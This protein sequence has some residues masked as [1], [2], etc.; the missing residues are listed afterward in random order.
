MVL[1]RTWFGWSFAAHV[2]PASL[3]RWLHDIV[4]G[5]AGIALLIYRHRHADAG[6]PDRPAVDGDNPG[7]N[8]A[9][10]A[11]STS[12][13]PC[14]RGVGSGS[15]G[16][17]EPRSRPG[18]ERGEGAAG[19]GEP[20]GESGPGPS[21]PRGVAELVRLPRPTLLD[22]Y[23]GKAYLRVLA[24]AFA[25]LL[26][27]STSV[28]H[29][30]VGQSV[31]GTGDGVPARPLP[32]PTPRRSSSTTCCRWRPWWHLVTSGSS[33]SRAS[34]SACAPAAS[35]STGPRCR[36]RSSACSGAV[37]LFSAGGVVPR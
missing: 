1:P 34:S 31:Q 37:R 10:A 27:T 2:F 4:L 7:S 14:R 30:L 13:Q 23:V 29:R 32:V 9:A 19:E 33:P 12:R 16:S 21:R 22:A 17:P 11:V 5:L 36:C 6:V 15:P 3:A 20:A 28:V 35:A 8:Q 18:A 25:G 26:G 24:L